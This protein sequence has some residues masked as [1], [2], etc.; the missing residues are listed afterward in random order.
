[1]SPPS[2]ISKEEKKDSTVSVT[3]RLGL[4]TIT[5]RILGL[6]RDVLLTFSLGAGLQSDIFVVALRLPG[7]VRQMSAEGAL[8]ASFVPVY[9]HLHH[10][11]PAA[12]LPFAKKLA[13]RL[14]FSLLFLTL[15]AFLGTTPLLS[16][17]A[18]RLLEDP[19][20]SSLS[21]LSVRIAFP[22]IIFISLTALW[23]AIF[24]THGRFTIPAATGLS[25]NILLI[26]TL[27]LLPSTGE[28]NV[29]YLSAAIPLS[30]LLQL[31]LLSLYNRQQKRLLFPSVS[32]PTNVHAEVKAALKQFSRKF[33]P[34][35][36]GTGIYQING[37]VDTFFAALLPAG[38]IAHLY[39][40]DRLYQ[41]PLGVLGAT[42]SI[43]LLTSVSRYVTKN[44][45]KQAFETQ[46]RLLEFILFLGLPACLGLIIFRDV[47][48]D[49]LFRH[50]AYHFEDARITAYTLLG[51]SLGLPA[52]LMSKIANAPFFARGNTK[53]PLI[54]LFI[55]VISNAVLDKLLLPSLGL[56]GISLS[57]AL[58][59]WLY[60][61]GLFWQMKKQHL[62]V[63]DELFWRRLRKVII[64]TFAMGAIL[65][66]F[67]FFIPYDPDSS[68]TLRIFYVVF[69][70]IIGLLS[71]GLI[72]FF[73][74]KTY[75]L[76]FLHQKKNQE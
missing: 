74:L 7:M 31:F 36:L 56:M 55:G 63:S 29:I 24:N 19:Q 14:F 35:A 53:T 50:G 69:C 67:R 11:H 10:N 47:F 61:G 64:A 28:H 23:T 13:R 71:Y 66:I 51:F 22:F 20:S 30:G 2:T 46:N 25:F 6:V 41:L 48:V 52:S 70:L 17:L 27:V 62:W 72:Q 58:S 60:V 75:H 68:R 59:A 45:G 54:F 21:I 3:S 33:F 43:S 49:V 39:Y 8:N 42:A 15:L 37:L 40:A 1:M 16:L 4:V 57:T 5:S 38:S 32:S 26:L 12:A 9:S 65:C 76:K 18:A 34:T 44:Q 73:F